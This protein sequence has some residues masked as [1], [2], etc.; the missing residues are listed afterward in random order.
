MGMG[1]TNILE[2]IAA[3][4]G[5][6]NGVK[7]I[8]T[9]SLDVPN[10]GVLFA[11]SALIVSGLLSHG[12]KYFQLPQGY[13]RLDSI[14]LLLAFMAIARI[15]TVEDLRYCSPGEWGKILGLDRIPEA[16]TLRQK[17]GAKTHNI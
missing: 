8:F 14:F 9:A 15:K 13:Y 12:E 6:L 1:A 10:R 16:K 7:P 5:E 2:R 17:I 4:L 3:S 11:L